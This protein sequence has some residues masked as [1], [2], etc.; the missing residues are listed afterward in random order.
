MGSDYRKYNVEMRWQCQDFRMW[1]RGIDRAVC[2]LETYRDK[3]SVYF[4]ASNL[5]PSEN[6]AEERKEYHFVMMGAEDGGLLHRDFGV[7]SVNQ[8]GEGSLWQKFDGPSLSCY[9]HCLLLALNQ[10]TGKTVCILSGQTPFFQ[11]KTASRK[12]GEPGGRFEQI[13]G[14]DF[15]KWN[16]AD[17]IAPF[18]PE[19]DETGAIWLRREWRG[20]VPDPLKLCCVQIEK[21]GHYIIGRK[22][23][24]R[25]A[26]VP[27]RFLMAEMPGGKKGGFSLWQ[28]IRGGETFF[29]DLGELKGSLQE[30]LY[31]YWIGE[32]DEETGEIRPL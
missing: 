13:W 18:T 29:D 31:G 21:Y 7:F 23:Q 27:G 14:K 4:A 20:Q 30:E 32:I 26:G 24:R 9:T 2:V 6:L 5:L 25:F 11:E 22:E 15:R 19:K 3:R 28:P 10:E 1:K 17:Q 12:G 8:S 16:P